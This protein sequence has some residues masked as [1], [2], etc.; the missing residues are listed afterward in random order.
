[1]D[2]CLEASESK[3]GLWLD[4]RQF[5]AVRAMTKDDADEQKRKK[6]EKEAKDSR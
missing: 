5:Y 4:D 2:K 6:K 3:S 1:M